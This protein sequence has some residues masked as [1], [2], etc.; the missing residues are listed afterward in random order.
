MASGTVYPA[1]IGKFAVDEIYILFLKKG[2]GGNWMLNA[3]HRSIMK[4][5]DDGYATG[6]VEVPPHPDGLG[7]SYQH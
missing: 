6:G 4:I 1:Q 7:S 5:S 2:E 3:G